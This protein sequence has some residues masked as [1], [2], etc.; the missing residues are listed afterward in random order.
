MLVLPTNA[1]TL[2]LSASFVAS[3]ATCCGSEPCSST[4]YLTGW[5]LM[6][7]LSLTQLK[8][9]L[10]AVVIG[11][12]SMPGIFVTIAPSLTGVPVA[13]FPFASPHFTAA[14][15]AVLLVPPPPPP[16][17]RTATTPTSAIG[18]TS[19]RHLLL[20]VAPPQDAVLAAAPAS[21]GST[22]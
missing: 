19:L 17:A 16:A 20:T 13:F 12:K 15:D 1:W 6:P 22:R 8:Y 5:P 3:D 14:L 21:Q 4:M 7:P 2:S 10:A 11:V 9:A 18:P